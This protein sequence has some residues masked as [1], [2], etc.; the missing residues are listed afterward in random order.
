MSRIAWKSLRVRW[1]SLVG[2]FVALAL[3]VALMAVMLLGL[4]ATARLPWGEAAIGLN[5]AFGT[6]GGVSTFVAGFVIASTFSYV[7]AQ[8]QRELGLL[9]L[10]GASRGQIRRMVLLE[11]VAVG[12]AAS[13]AGCALGAVGAPR[14]GRELVRVGT[15]PEGFAIGTGIWPL[16]AAFATGLLVA[17]AGVAAA[18]HR[19][20]RLGPLDALREADVNSR[21]M[22]VGRWCWGLGLLATAAVLVGVALVD[23]PASLLRRKNYTVQPMALISACG[24][25]VP[26]L[27]RPLLHGLGALPARLT[28][29]AGRLVRA[30]ALGGI[31]RTGAVAA[32]VLV[33]VAL[34]GSLLGGMDTVA[35]GRAAEARAQSTADQ[36]VTP[37]PGSDVGSLVR[38]L[39]AVPGLLVSPSAAAA[40]SVVESDGVTVRTEA[41][42]VDPATYREVARLPLLAGSLAELDDES[43]LLPEEWEQHTVGAPVELVLAD[44]ARRTLRVAGVLRD[45]TGNNGLY[46]TARNAPGARTDRIELRGGRVAET[47]AVVGRYGAEVVDRER[48]LAVHYPVSPNRVAWLRA[49]LVLG[50]AL[51]YTAIG[52]ANTLVLATADRKRE[53][54]QLRLAGATRWQVIRVVTA[55]SLLAVAAGGLL[56]AV[57]TGVNLTGMQ[58]ALRLLGVEPPVVVPWGALAGVAGGCAA[59]AVPFTVVA[60]A[61][62][63]R[64]RPVTVIG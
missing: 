9:R 42:A 53:L 24:L 35:A 20:G 54:A 25:L 59:V 7:V 64:R 8:R 5:S 13:V 33:S 36:V 15:A 49:V 58:L 45:G 2:A 27:A 21:V 37:R 51:V 19:A 44:G 57:V 61:W 10:T 56:G 47:A 29:Y 17:V 52:L 34:A 60:A 39:R 16:C 11:A 1:V 12:V 62:A 55:E 31:R 23:E 50:L 63:L 22:T 40:V 3:G 4:A 14:L 32:P 28:S 43:V 38:E 6:A 30:N 41:R 26:V 48:W 18:A 46:V